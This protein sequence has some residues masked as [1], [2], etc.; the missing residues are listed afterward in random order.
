MG[1]RNGGNEGLALALRVRD[2][3]DDVWLRNTLR[4]ED[5]ELLGS[6]GQAVPVTWLWCSTA[7]AQRLVICWSRIFIDH[8]GMLFPLLNGAASLPPWHQIPCR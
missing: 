2:R 4:V 7:N 1:L 6:D 5:A 3:R 8:C